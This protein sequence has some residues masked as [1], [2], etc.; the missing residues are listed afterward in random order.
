MKLFSWPNKSWRN[1]LVLATTVVVMVLFASHPELRLLLPVID[2]LGLDLFLMLVGA[3]LWSYV[4]PAASLLH[5]SVVR[6][7][8]RKAYRVLLFFGFGCAGPY[9]HARLSVRFP[10]LAAAS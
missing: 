2:A 10:L 4:R 6:P 5:A 8:L 7:A 3:Q 1:R 9:V